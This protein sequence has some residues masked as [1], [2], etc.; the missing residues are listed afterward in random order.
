MRRRTS[1][2]PQSLLSTRCAVA[3]LLAHARRQ[4][5]VPGVRGAA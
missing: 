2:L 1:P 4:G 5:A 3:M